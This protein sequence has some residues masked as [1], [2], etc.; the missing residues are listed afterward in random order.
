MYKHT[1][2]FKIGKFRLSFTRAW[3]TSAQLRKANPFRYKLMLQYGKGAGHVNGMTMFF[4]YNLYRGWTGDSNLR[5]DKNGIVMALNSASGSTRK[6]IQIGITLN[7][8]VIPYV[9]GN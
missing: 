6:L 3:E 1:E 4:A 5:C 8:N 9:D 2:L 7:A